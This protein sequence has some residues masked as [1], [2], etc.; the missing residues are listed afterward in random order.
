[1]NI[2]RVSFNN[3]KLDIDTQISETEIKD[4]DTRITF[5]RKF[6]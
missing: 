1:M 6:K 5:K 2:F 3:S 4:G